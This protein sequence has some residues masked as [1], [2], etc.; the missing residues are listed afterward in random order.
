MGQ[1]IA[2]RFFH[3]PYRYRKMQGSVKSDQY[4]F[5]APGSVSLRSTIVQLTNADVLDDW[6]V[7]RYHLFTCDGVSLYRGDVAHKPWRLRRLEQLDWTDN[8]SRQFGFTA[9]TDS[10]ARYAEPINVQFKP[11]VNLTYI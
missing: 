3:L 2:R 7:K 4:L 9:G 8:L 6:L 1:F 5:N 11:F 10:R